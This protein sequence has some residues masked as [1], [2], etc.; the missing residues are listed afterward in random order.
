MATCGDWLAPRFMGR[1]ALYKPPLLAWSAGLS[2]KI[3]GVSRL[4]LRLPSAIFASLAGGLLF[5]WAAEVYNW[6]A[7]VAGGPPLLSH[8]L[9]DLLCTL[10][11]TDGLLVSFCISAFF[12]LFSDPWLVA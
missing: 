6:K 4:A 7:G 1:V 2:A 8:H 5:L 10:C 11:M 12:A 3:F 9:W